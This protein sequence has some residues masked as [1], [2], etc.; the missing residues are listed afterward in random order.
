MQFDSTSYEVLKRIV[1]FP[2]KMRALLANMGFVLQISGI[3]LVLP[4]ILSFIN[5][6]LVATVG[7]FITATIFL[8][9]G[10]CL[11]HSVNDAL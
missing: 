8:I 3:F 7:L 11:I 9:I 6:E 4:I 10:F 5:N 2:D 1:I